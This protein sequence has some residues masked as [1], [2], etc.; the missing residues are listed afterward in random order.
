VPVRSALFGAVIGVLGVLAALTFSSGVGDAVGHPERFGQTHQLES[1]FG[2]NNSDFGPVDEMLPLIARDADVVSVNDTRID[3]GQVGDV[4]VSVVS[5]DPVREALEVVVTRGRLPDRQGEVALAPRTAKALGADLGDS[6]E[7]SGTRGRQE[8]AITGLAFVPAGPH[9][10]YATGAWVTRQT[11]DDL[12]GGFRFHAGLI[13]LRAEA[14]PEA[15]SARLQQGAGEGAVEFTPPSPPPEVAEIQQVR[16][17]PLFLAGF[18]AVLALGAIGHA[19]ATAVRR[20]RHDLAS[21]RALGITRWQ[22][23]AMVVTQA[24]VLVLVGLAVGA[25]LGTALGRTVWRSVAESTPLQY[26]PPVAWWALILAAPVALVAANMLAVWPSHR[27]ASLRVSQ[28]FRA[29]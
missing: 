25:P 10:D 15:V 5:L 8:L 13:A 20:R 3:V 11:Y 19:L 24:T 21:L 2:F 29:E 1:F 18:L 14:D 12:F 23:R 4:S 7:L 17:L 27:A 22:C 28:I 9:N 16:A 6:L 26:L